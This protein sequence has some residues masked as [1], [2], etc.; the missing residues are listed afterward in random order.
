MFDLSPTFLQIEFKKKFNLENL[1]GIVNASIFFSVHHTQIIGI[2][3]VIISNEP[4]D[5]V[6]R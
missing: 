2:Q 3:T 1:K 4:I 6:M 5:L